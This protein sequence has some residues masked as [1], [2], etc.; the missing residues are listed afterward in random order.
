MK[1]DIKEGLAYAL[2]LGALPLLLLL[3]ALIVELFN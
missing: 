2:H 3:T 1:R